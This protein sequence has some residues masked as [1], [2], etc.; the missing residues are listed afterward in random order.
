M[1]RADYSLVGENGVSS[2]TI[3]AA[4]NSDSLKAQTSLARTSNELSKTF[5]RLSS[6]LRINSASD[7]PAGLALAD[8]LRSDARVA[9]VAVRNANDGLSL[10]AIAD[11]GLSEIGN[12]LTRMAELAT[13]SANGIYTTTQR[14]ALSSEFL[15]LGS[16]ID[17]IAKTTTFNGLSLL[18]SS[19]NI[20]LQ[21]GIDSTSNSQITMTAVR[22]TLD[23]LGLATAGS[24]AMNYTIIST[25][26]TLS[27]AAATTAL[28]AI[29]TAINTLGSTRGV[30]GAAESRLNTAINYLTV[31]RE[32]FVAAESRIRDADV[33][34]EVANMVRLQV[35]QQS[36]TA[37]LAQANQQPALVLKLLG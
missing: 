26:S 6:G 11:A 34:E 17:R 29:Q 10:A 22:G 1:W 33:A 24:S 20:T 14:S 18:S 15:A 7:D 31:V 4:S 28:S 9:A 16:E 8:G 36:G 13:Q 25:T 21:V 12:L 19:Q 5:E 27:Q 32:N 30:V 23:S 2:M 37:V 35:L 3:T